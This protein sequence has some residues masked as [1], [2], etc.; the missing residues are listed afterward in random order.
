MVLA[1]RIFHDVLMLYVFAPTC[2]LLGVMLDCCSK[3]DAPCWTAV[4]YRWLLLD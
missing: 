2:D 1:S 4:L 3:A